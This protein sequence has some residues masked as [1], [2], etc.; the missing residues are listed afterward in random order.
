MKKI[1]CNKLK[2]G[3]LFCYKM[4]N[5]I[6][7]GIYLGNKHAMIVASR[8]IGN[9]GWRRFKVNKIYKLNF[10]SGPVYSLK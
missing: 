2:T 8:T 4:P 5:N 10:D 6:L 7:Y 1:D 3:D 9:E